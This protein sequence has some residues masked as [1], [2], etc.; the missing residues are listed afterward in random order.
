MSM[1]CSVFAVSSQQADQLRED[2]EFL[3]ELLSAPN[4][5]VGNDWHG[6]HYLLT[7]TA[8]GHPAPR[9]FLVE[10]GEEINGTDGGYGPAR[11]FAPREVDE[12]HS[13]LVDITEEELWSR[14]D[15]KRMN[16]DKVYPFNWHVEPELKRK[17]YLTTFQE[18]RQF[19]DQASRRGQCLVV[20]LT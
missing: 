2:A 12:I 18:L 15:A 17:L 11:L 6:F 3:L 16:A 10:G 8:A 14:F 9:G 1:N 13:V 4:V 20:S 7:G 19:V 5:D